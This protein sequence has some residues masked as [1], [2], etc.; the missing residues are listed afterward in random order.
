MS[1]LQWPLCEGDDDGDDDMGTLETY[2][3]LPR[4]VNASLGSTPRVPPL[5]LESSGCLGPG[6]HGGQSTWWDVNG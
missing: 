1:A 4:K 3:M 5:R 2:T 6:S